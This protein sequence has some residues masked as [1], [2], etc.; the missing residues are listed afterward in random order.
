MIGVLEEHE[1]GSVIEVRGH[2][3]L[4]FPASHLLIFRSA[5]A[6]LLSEDVIYVPRWSFH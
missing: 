1:E 5:E 3:S 2:E 6:S 4:H